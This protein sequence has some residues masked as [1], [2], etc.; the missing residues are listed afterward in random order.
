MTLLITI[1]INTQCT[2]YVAVNFWEDI[3]QV[4]STFLLCKFTVRNTFFVVLVYISSFFII[5][6]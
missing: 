5:L 1:Q 6:T 3:D 4:K 2:L